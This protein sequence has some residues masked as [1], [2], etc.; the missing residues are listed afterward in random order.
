MYNG[1]LIFE[2]ST[3]ATLLKNKF[4]NRA[5]KFEKKIGLYGVF[6]RQ[7]SKTKLKT[8]NQNR[9]RNYVVIVRLDVE[10]NTSNT[11]RNFDAH[12]NSFLDLK[13]IFFFLSSEISIYTRAR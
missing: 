8:G 12:E 3:S 5:W 9:T 10:I 13:H 2:C 6:E 4:S 1:V 11:R 7:H